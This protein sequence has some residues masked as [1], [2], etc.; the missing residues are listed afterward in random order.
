MVVKDKTSKNIPLVIQYTNILH[1]YGVRS[2]E[3]IAFRDQYKDDRVFQHRARVLE[4]L[5]EHP[6]IVGEK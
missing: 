2:T 5:I 1:E 6:E 3:S 4:L